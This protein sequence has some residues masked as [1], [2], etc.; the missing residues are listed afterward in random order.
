VAVSEVAICNLA[1][2][3]LGAAR[4]TSLTEDS[5][6]ARHCNACYTMLRDQEIVAHPWS[7]A[8]KRATLAPDATAPDHDYLYAFSYPTN[9][10]RILP[11]ARNGLDWQM[12]NN[13]ILTNDGDTLE[14]LYLERVTD[15]TRF[16]PLFDDALA[17]RMADHMCE[18]ITQSNQKK[19]KATT[20]YNTAIRRAK[21][22][23]A[24]EQISAEPP[25]DPWLAARR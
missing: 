3:K 1:L 6:N 17:S 14:V 19:E 11:P 2:Q 24:I 16:H 21:R 7:F 4:I 13:K 20:D 8:K 15:P 10:L 9:C 12:E 5:V 18:A 25:E 23:N 22:T